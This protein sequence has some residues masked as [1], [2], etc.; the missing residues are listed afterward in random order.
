MSITLHS[1]VFPLI[2]DSSVQLLLFQ[3]YP[4][5]KLISL[6]VKIVINPF[7]QHRRIFVAVDGTTMKCC[8][9]YLRLIYMS[10]MRSDKD[11][12]VNDARTT[13]RSI[14]T[15]VKVSHMYEGA[16]LYCC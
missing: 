3:L 2:N 6:V 5:R 13:R 9:L 15:E 1:S 10:T 12:N 8:S 14:S 11:N 16:R 4:N 7:I